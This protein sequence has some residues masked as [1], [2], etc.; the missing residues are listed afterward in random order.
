MRE[1]RIEYYNILF[2]YIH[3][4]VHVHVYTHYTCI[5]MYIHVHVY[6]CIAGSEE[7]FKGEKW[8]ERTRGTFSA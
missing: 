8:W 1:L 2:M 4:H 3:V 5:Y 7:K 6:T